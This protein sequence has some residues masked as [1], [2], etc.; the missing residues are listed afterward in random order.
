MN[1]RLQSFIGGALALLGWAGVAPL[2]ADSP[3]VAGE[4]GCLPGGGGRLE[5][6]GLLS[7]TVASGRGRKA[8]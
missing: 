1:P 7:V 2:A 4:P 6:S 5:S 3:A 8:R